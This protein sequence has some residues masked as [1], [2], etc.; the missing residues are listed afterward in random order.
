MVCILL[1][2]E[3]PVADMNPQEDCGARLVRIER[4]LAVV[5][6]RLRALEASGDAPAIR[7]GLPAP[8]DVP[9]RP[10]L[11][12]PGAAVTTDITGLATLLGRT[13]IV[14]GGAYLLRALTESGRL[15]HGPG[16]VIGLAYAL[17]WLAAAW[18]DA[19]VRR[20]S[21]QFH[22][23]TGLLIGLPLVLEATTRF[24][25]LRPGAAALVFAVLSATAFVVARRA[26]LDAVSGVAGF[27]TLG[28]GVAAALATNHHAAFSLLL[29]CLGT[30]TY[31]LA[32]EP[33][34]GWLRWPT[35]IAAGLSVVAVTMRER[36]TPPLE[37]AGLTLITQAV[38]VATMQGS[39]AVRVLLLGRNVR[40]FDML[41]AASGLIIGV[42]GAVLVARGSPAGLGLIGS[43][44][45]VLASGASLAAFIRL[46]DRPALARSYHA[47][48]IFGMVTTVAA[49]VL[50]M[51]G[52]LL[53]TTA[54]LLSLATITF[55]ARR[56]DGYAPL[57]A[58]AYVTT[59]LAASG[60]LGLGLTAWVRSVTPWPSVPLLAGLSL[61]ATAVCSTLRPPRPGAMG[62]LLAR[63][64]RT[65]IA[66]ACVF[67]AGGACLILLAPVVAGT[68]MD[69]GILASLRT[70]VLSLIVVGLGASSR[71]PALAVF[72]SL[73]YP[74]LVLGGLRL[75]ADD[76]R[77]SRP[78]TLFVA[79]ACY[80]IAWVLG[81][82]L[83]ARATRRPA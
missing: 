4:D 64:G 44:T 37:T 63:S 45:A 59:A 26:R 30:M 11:P 34:R 27:G 28:A 53:T 8:V 67:G 82:R 25:F 39:L 13:F 58:A 42:G 18:R 79:L 55:G 43:V 2:Q 71:W 22:G 24:G 46:A 20:N 35:A 56:L 77:H 54:L 29:I 33:A 21:A 7:P 41:Q 69:A 78:S 75:V 40:L 6:E 31:W 81:P 38:L 60:A 51:R 47:F 16:I 61:A 57:H 1:P 62:D 76:F 74:V 50:L 68:P 73:V 14:F 65:V 52:A 48:A 23:V 66:F 49:L 15:P 5:M 36:A 80:G 3:G 12:T 9:R 32:E 83:A 17:T 72:A 70:V 10:E 19:P